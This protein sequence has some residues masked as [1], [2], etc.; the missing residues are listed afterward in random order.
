MFTE[1]ENIRVVQL[2]DRL[3]DQVWGAIQMWP[4]FEKWALG[5]QIVRAV[6]SIG[7]NIVEGFG[8]HHAQDTLRFYYM[9]RG[10]LE[11]SGYWLRK[12]IHRELIGSES[13]SKLLTDLDLLSRLLNAF[14][15]AH[16]KRSSSAHS[17][18][19]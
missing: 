9:A 2:A 10:S 4:N 16:R 6:D 7:A 1:A 15:T 8:R 12:A 3:S 18:I 19:S 13:G 14:I 5:M 11:E 17:T